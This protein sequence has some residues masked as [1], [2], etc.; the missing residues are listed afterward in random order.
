MIDYRAVDFADA[1][2]E[3]VGEHAVD[4]AYDSVGKDTWER[5]MG[6]LRPRGY[7]VVYGNSSGPVPPIEPQKLAGG[8]S[9]FVTRPTIVHYLRTREELLQRAGEVFGAIRDGSL[10]VRIGA[11]YPLAEAA[12][13][14]RDLEARKTVGKLLLIP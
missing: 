4:V 8:G 3:L 6:T 12:Q 5:S 9:L 7:L 13:A 1:V 14:H 10:K 2:R 11:T